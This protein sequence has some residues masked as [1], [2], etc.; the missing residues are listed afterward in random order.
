[1]AA[2]FSATRA[3]NLILR[4]TA[5]DRGAVRSFSSFSYT[6]KENVS[7]RPNFGVVSVGH[8]KC[9][10]YLFSQ[11]YC[12][13]TANKTGKIYIEFTCKKCNSRNK[14]F[15]SKVA[16]TTGV[17]IITC[18]GCSNNHLIADNLNWFTDL[19]GKKNIEDILKEKGESV[20]KV[21]F[22]EDGV[23]EVVDNTSVSLVD[24]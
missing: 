21:L 16:Y 20:K 17:V 6:F 3:S 11:R 14:K 22:S 4:L 1:M 24:K 9:L 7:N 23:S 18:E 15:M 13:T 12:S 8:I 5:F 2:R 10:N 19:N